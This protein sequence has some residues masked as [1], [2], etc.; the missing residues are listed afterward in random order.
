LTV[1]TVG[2]YSV[3]VKFK[4]SACFSVRNIT[5]THSDT[6][7]IISLDI[8]DLSQN[9][10]VTINTE[11]KGK[12]QY[13][14]SGFDG[15]FQDSNVFKDIEP[16]IYTAIVKDLN[17]C[18]FDQKPAF[19]IG[20]PPF[21]TPNGDGYNDYWSIKGLDATT[22]FTALSIYDQ[23]GKLIKQ[24]NPTE[25]GWDGTL[26]GFPVPAN[27]YWFTLVLAN[28]REAKGHFSLKR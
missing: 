5:V 6:P 9:N 18:G 13:S 15:Y 24:I 12:Y 17:K 25:Q 20:A 4:N 16:G 27:D 3:G 8:H 10:S 21:F 11:G 2:Q 7:K 1:T 28:G 23:W 26:N 14:I 22:N 19:V